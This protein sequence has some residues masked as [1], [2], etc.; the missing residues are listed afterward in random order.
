LIVTLCEDFKYIE[1]HIENSICAPFM[2]DHVLEEEG[3]CTKTQLFEL[4]SMPEETPRDL[5]PDEDDE[6]EEEELLNITNTDGTP[7]E[8]TMVDIP[9]TDDVDTDVDVDKLKKVIADQQDKLDYLQ[10]SIAEQAK[11]ALDNQKQHR[12]VLDNAI[13]WSVRILWVMALIGTSYTTHLLDTG[14]IHKLFPWM[15][16]K[17]QVQVVEKQIQ[18]KEV[19]TER[20]VLR[21]TGMFMKYVNKQHSDDIFVM[22]QGERFIVNGTGKRYKYAQKIPINIMCKKTEYKP[23][24]VGRS[25]NNNKLVILK[26]YTDGIKM[27]YEFPPEFR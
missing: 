24:F 15:E 2:P 1:K 16:P 8:E 19:K 18:V 14:N 9:D 4:I 12:P 13:T 27:N 25:P 17:V 3:Y 7:L 5:E 20:F 26:V 6:I 10:R 21:T 23:D 11:A 22:V